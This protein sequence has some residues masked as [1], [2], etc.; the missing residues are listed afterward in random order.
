MSPELRIF[1]QLEK[2]GKDREKEEGKEGASRKERREKAIMW[3][4]VSTRPTHYYSAYATMK[5]AEQTQEGG[6]VR[7]TSVYGSSQKY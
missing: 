7:M 2:G 5:E 1:T 4:F 3:H 6:H